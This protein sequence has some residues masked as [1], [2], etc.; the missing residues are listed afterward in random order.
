MRYKGR[1]VFAVAGD[2]HVRQAGLAISF[3]KRLTRRDIL[4]VQARSDCRVDHDE[5]I[6]VET[7]SGMSDRQAGIFLKTGLAQ[8]F[9]NHETYCYLDSDVIAVS[10]DVD[11]IFS[12]ALGPIAFG[13]D[14]ARIDVFSRYAVRCFCAT[15]P[16][17]HLRERMEY[18]FSVRVKD[19]DWTMWNGG[20]FVCRPGSG[21]FMERWHEMALRIL[22]NPFWHIRDQGALALAAWQLGLQDLPLLDARFNLI[23]DRFNGFPE[24]QRRDL[25]PEQFAVRKDYQLYPDRSDSIPAFLHFINGGAG[26]T[27]WRNWDEVVAHHA[28]LMAQ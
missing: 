8:I 9:G 19:P 23:V 17:T 2:A 24:H 5:I 20:V 6:H 13:A 18:D 22:K 11:E 28:G 26:Q 25:P 10:S 14:H 7:P 27:G 3:L 16:C 15:P 4:L 1:F 21:A 12:Q